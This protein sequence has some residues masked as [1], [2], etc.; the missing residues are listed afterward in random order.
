MCK[1]LKKINAEGYE[2]DK[3]LMPHYLLNYEK[4]FP[5]LAEKEIKLLELG[6]NYG[7]SLKMWRDYF[8]KGLIV[9]IDINNIDI[10]DP[11]GRIKF[12]SGLQEDEKLLDKVSAEC[13]PEGFD[14]IIDDCS[15][16]GSLS[17][18]S[19]W[20]LFENHLKPGGIYVIEDWGTGY[21]DS[22]FDGKRYDFKERGKDQ[23]SLMNKIIKKIKQDDPKR[24]K[25]HDFGMV[26]FIKSLIDEC[27]MEDITNE[28]FGIPPKR[29][30]KI[31]RMQIS[32]GIVFIFKV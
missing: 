31:D 9:G 23:P 28:R 22:W 8:E 20:Y 12:Y 26:G 10:E 30:S 21:W 17:Q 1:M 18:K 25:S 19:F 27:G 15:H 14:I 29:T 2:T 7:G 3:T 4:F 5:D 13:A 6:V 24:I 16:I 32:L 11:T